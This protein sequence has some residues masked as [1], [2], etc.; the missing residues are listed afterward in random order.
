MTEQL[1]AG[2]GYDYQSDWSSDGRW[3]AYAKYATDAV[4][5]WALDVTTEHA[6]RDEG[7]SRPAPRG[8]DPEGLYFGNSRV[9]IVP[10]PTSLL[11]STFP[12]C[13]RTML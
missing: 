5:L 12:P 7:S 13:R 11:I 2:P 8:D 6:H 3:I 10:W 1:T 9:T 4:G